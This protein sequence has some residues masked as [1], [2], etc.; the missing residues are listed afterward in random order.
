MVLGQADGPL[1]DRQL[2]RGRA[3]LPGHIEAL[4]GAGAAEHERARIRGIGQEVVHGGIARRRPADTVLADAPARQPLALGD[5]LPDDLARRPEPAPEHE[6][7]P[8]RVTHLLVAREHDPVALVAL[9]PDRQ[10][11]PQLPPRGLAAQPAVQPRA[12]QVQLGLGHRALEPE[13]QTV[14]EVSRRIDAVGVGDQ[15]PR[16]RAQIQQLMP[17]RRR[18]RQPRGL[19]RQDQPDLSEPDLRNELLEAEPAIA[20]HA[21]ATGVL[22]DHRHRFARPAK[23]DRALAQRILTRLGLPVALHL[24]G[25]RLAHI[26]DRAPTPVRFGDLAPIAHRAPPRSAAPATP[27]A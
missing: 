15:R 14:V 7:A 13:Q 10:V 26:H 1:L 23:L 19:Q 27:P 22:I 18:P 11:H 12:D 9:E 17:V 5:Q 3:H 25:R 16:Q 20:A 6:H 4:V 2:A 8:D 21:R 24:P